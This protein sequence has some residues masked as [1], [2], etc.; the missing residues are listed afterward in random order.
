MHRRGIAFFGEAFEDADVIEL[1]R[2]LEPLDPVGELG[3]CLVV[4]ERV[5]RVRP[6]GFVRFVLVGVAGPAPWEKPRIAGH[7]LNAVLLVPE[8]GEL[9]IDLG[10]EIRVQLH[11]FGQQPAPA[12]TVRLGALKGIGQ[13]VENGIPVGVDRSAG[14]GVSPPVVAAGVIRKL[15]QIGQGL[16]LPGPPAGAV[17]HHHVGKRK[18]QLGDLFFVRFFLRQFHR[19]DHQLHRSNTIPLVSA[20]VLPATAVVTAAEL[21]GDQVPPV[22]DLVVGLGGVPHQPPVAGV[23]VDDLFPKRIDFVNTVQPLEAINR[24]TQVAAHRLRIVFFVQGELAV[25]LVGILVVAVPVPLGGLRP[26]GGR[27]RV[28]AEDVTGCQ[29]HQA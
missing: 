21:T 20:G 8:G 25:R 29:H 3:E 17:L 13:V 23:G 7:G 9:I 24:L 6:A 12:L 11:R 16:Q 27:F 15:G 4:L 19:L 18:V 10:F 26:Q 28:L 1:V 22:V 5:H 2:Q 14:G